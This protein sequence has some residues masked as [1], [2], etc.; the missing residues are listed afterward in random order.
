M[1]YKLVFIE[2]FVRIC[3]GGWL[4]P[5]Q[6]KYTEPGA[7]A[8]APLR[9]L[10]KIGVYRTV[11]QSKNERSLRTSPQIGVAIPSGDRKTFAVA[12]TLSLLKKGSDPTAAGG[13][14]REGSEWPQSAA[15]PL[16]RAMAAPGTATGDHW[17]PA[18]I[19]KFTKQQA[20][21]ARPYG[22]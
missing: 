13:G 21:N 20:G 3:R 4:Y 9:I 22:L 6:G 12:R 8:D 19:G 15:S 5:P 18:R 2:L 11:A 17:S 14:G 1:T 10:L 16:C 7:Y